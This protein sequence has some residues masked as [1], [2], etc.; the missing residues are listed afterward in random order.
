MNQHQSDDKPHVPRK[1]IYKTP[2]N[3]SSVVVR[4]E[5]IE[6]PA[7][8]LSQMVVV[9]QDDSNKKITFN[10][11]GDAMVDGRESFFSVKLKTNKWTAYLS[12]DI[13]SIIK[14]V[15]ISLPHNQNLIL[16]DIND[17]ATLSSI[18]H[19]CSA[20]DNQM[21]SNW[22]T[23]LNSL[24]QFNRSSGASSARRFLSIHEE[25]EYRTMCFQLNLSGIMSS[26][27][28]IPLVLLNGLK[29]DI[30]LETATNAFHYDAE[31][32]KNYETIFSVT[33]MPFSKPYTSM[34]SEEKTLVTDQIKA[35][36]NRSDPDNNS[37]L[38]YTVHSP[39]FH[40]QTIYMSSN[41][42]DSLIKVASESQNGVTM[43][44]NTYRNNLIT[45][46]SQYCSFAFNDSV[47]NL[48]NIYMVTQSR[49]SSLTSHFNYFS[50]ALKN[51]TF[52]VGSRIYNKVD[53]Q[54]PSLAI[55]SSL[56]SLGT[57]GRYYTHNLNSKDYFTS[58]NVHVFNFENTRDSNSVQ[59]GINTTNGRNLRVELE[60]NDTPSTSSVISPTD[61][62]VLA[63]F[64]KVSSYSQVHLTSFIEFSKM[65]RINNSGIL[66][67]E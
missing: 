15:T 21:N 17:Y 49:D 58:K 53:N 37:P 47:Q 30:Y 6:Y 3:S 44:F 20:D 29:I 59:S 18:I 40:A 41:Y 62:S 4:R 32:E 5:I 52:R 16:E 60:F 65:I 55:V 57:F 28:Y 35:M 25:G 42:I 67:T 45:P 12:S 33:D 39:I 31:N 26:E 13:T 36:T 7:V 11:S 50:R 19:I 64:D 34:T 56:I 51:F 8:A 10:I 48:K 43:H 2:T 22:Y 54:S 27:N 9:G 66:S 61:N 1:A 23:G 38:I 46:Q 63:N 14:R 24:S